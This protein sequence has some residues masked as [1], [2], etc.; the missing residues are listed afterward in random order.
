MSY[1]RSQ[2][3]LAWRIIIS[4]LRSA[5]RTAAQR[6]SAVQCR[7]GPCPAV[8]CRALPV[9]CRAVRCCAV[10]CHAVPCCVIFA[11]LF[12]HARAVPCG[13]VLCGAVPCCVLFAVLSPHAQSIIRSVT[14]PVLL[15]YVPGTILLNQEKNALTAQLSPAIR[16]SAAQRCAVPCLA[17]RCFAVLRCAFFRTYSSTRYHAI[18]GSDQYVCT[19]VLVFFPLSSFD[20]PL[21]FLLSLKIKTPVLAIRT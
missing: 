8:P 7:A 15:L 1:L 9:P 14:P 11:V 6:R 19:C 10:L 2:L 17:L 13:A 4:S 20:C 16:S 21:S 5:E 18:Q 12:L 3:S